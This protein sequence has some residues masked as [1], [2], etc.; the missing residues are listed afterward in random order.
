VTANPSLSSK[1]W[2]VSGCALMAEVLPNQYVVLVFAKIVGRRRHSVEKAISLAEGRFVFSGFYFICPPWLTASAARAV[3]VGGGLMPVGGGLMSVDA[4]LMSVGVRLMSMGEGV[5]LVDVR[6]MSVPGQPMSV[7]TRLF[8]FPP[9][10]GVHGVIF[11][12]TPA[13]VKCRCRAV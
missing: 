10:T 12:N 9:C 7:R 8:H 6:L 13:P 3:S 1:L 5:M 2:L 11:W 4:G